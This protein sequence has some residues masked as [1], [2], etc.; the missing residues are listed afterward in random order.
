MKSLLLKYGKTILFWLLGLIAFFILNEVFTFGFVPLF[1]L[2]VL[3]MLYPILFPEYTD[4]ESLQMSVTRHIH[5]SVLI[6]IFGCLSLHA[7][8]KYINPDPGVF[9]NND[10]HALRI[11]GVAINDPDDF[12]L[13]GNSSKAFLD[14]DEFN[15]EL[16][17]RGFD[18]D[19]ESVRLELKGF[20]SPVYYA[21]S[22]KQN[23]VSDNMPCFSAGE[24]VT[25]VSSLKNSPSVT[26]T[27]EENHL[28]RWKNLFGN[29][30][31]HNRDTSVYTFSV[32]NGSEN[33]QSSRTVFIKNGISLADMSAGV[34]LDMPVEGINVVRNIIRTEIDNKEF[35]DF[36][37]TRKLRP[38]GYKEYYES[39]G[40]KYTFELTDQAQVEKIIVNGRE[41]RVGKDDSRKIDIKLNK[42]FF[43]GFADHKTA[44]M[45]F[46]LHE[47]KL[48]LEWQLPKY[49][50][51]SSIDGNKENTVMITT[52][53]FDAAAKIDGEYQLIPSFTENILLFNLFEKKDNVNHM[54]PCYLSF[55]S[56]ASNVP[57]TFTLHA[58]EGS[59]KGLQTIDRYFRQ[60]SL[61]YR[62]DKNNQ[63]KY[64]CYFR[65][66]KPIGKTAE[67]EWLVTVENFKETTPFDA[68]T[69]TWVLIITVLCCAV[70]M[71]CGSWRTYTSVEYIA[72]LMLIAFLTIRL[73]L[74]WRT[75]VFVP[76]TSI[77]AAEFNK[78]RDVDLLG[79]RGGIELMLTG[80]F[81]GIVL[82]KFLIVR[83]N[84]FFSIIH[85]LIRKIFAT[86]RRALAWILG[87]YAAAFLFAL[88]VPARIGNIIIPVFVAI[89]L[90]YLIA[91]RF[92]TS[93]MDDYDWSPYDD[94]IGARKDA[95]IM[96]LI[97]LCCV[98]VFTFVK[99]A[100]FGVMFIMFSVLYM[101]FRFMDLFL[102]TTS[103]KT[104]AMSF[105]SDLLYFCAILFV[106]FYKRLFIILFNNPVL[107]FI[108]LF[109][110]VLAV[111]FLMLTALNV[112]IDFRDRKFVI[113]TSAFVSCL[114]LCC[115]AGTFLVPKFIEG[116]HLEYRIRVHMDSSPDDVM[117]NHISTQQEQNKFLQ[118]SLND[119]ILDEYDYIGEEVK[120]F[121]DVNNRSGWDNGYFKMQP[122]S[123]V[124]ALW[125]AQTSDIV[126]SRYIIAEHSETL[127]VLFIIAYVIMMFI[128]IRF[129]AKRRWTKMLIVM[130]PMLLATQAMMIWLANTGRFI[131]F[132]QDFPLISIN[133]K[134]TTVYFV[135]LIFILISA[136]MSEK[137]YGAYDECDSDLYDHTDSI[138]KAQ[139]KLMLAAYGIVM[140]I[141]LVTRLKFILYGLLVFIAGML[142]RNFIKRP[143]DDDDEVMNDSRWPG[144]FKFVGSLSVVLILSFFVCKA[145]ENE[146]VERG[147]Y[148]LNE[149][150]NRANDDLERINGYFRDYQTRHKLE[151]SRDMSAMMPEF[152]DSLMLQGFFVE[153]SWHSHK[154]SVGTFA[155]KL[156][157]EYCEEGS[158]SNSINDI[159]YVRN[160]RSFSAS[161]KPHDVLEF[162]LK[163][164]YYTVQLPDRT[165][166]TWRGSIV[167]EADAIIS[168][169]EYGSSKKDGYEYV[170]LPNAITGVGDKVIFKAKPGMRIF[171]ST[172]VTDAKS[173]M[174][175]LC[176]NN[177]DKIFKGSRHLRLTSSEDEL[178]AMNVQ[179]NGQRTFIY[180]RGSELFWVRD[181]ASQVMN[182]KN[183]QK[184]SVKN[185]DDF[186]DDVH[187][188]INGDLTSQIYDV[189]RKKVDSG[190]DRSVVVA[191]GDGRIRAMVDYRKDPKYRLNPNDLQEIGNVLDEL[192]INGQ[193]QSSEEERYFSTFA[194]SPLRCGPGSSQKPIVWTAVT[195]QYHVDWWADL[196]LKAID[197]KRLSP[198]EHYHKYFDLPFYAG[199]SIEKSFKSIAGDEGFD[200]EKKGNRDVDITRDV[201][202]E[203]Y[204]E[205]SSNY[206]NAIMAYIGTFDAAQLDNMNASDYDS[207]DDNALFGKPESYSRRAYDKK[208]RDTSYLKRFPIMKIKESGKEFNFNTFLDNSRR[209]QEN[210]VL[211]QGLRENFSLHT[212]GGHNRELKDTISPTVSSLYPSLKKLAV[213]KHDDGHSTKELK[214][215]VRPSTSYFNISLRKD[216]KSEKQCNEYMVRSVAI[217]TNSAWNVSPVKM[218]EMYARAVTL[219]RSYELTLDPSVRPAGYTDFKLHGDWRN[220]S[221]YKED[222]NALITGMQKVFQN[223]GSAKGV[224]P[225]IDGYYVYGKT[226]TIDGL[227]GGVDK[228]DH[229]LAIMITDTE[230]TPKTDLKSIRFYVAY[231]VDYGKSGWTAINREIIEKI[232]SSDEFK[233][234]MNK[235]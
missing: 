94:P 153:T 183:S 56:S 109:F 216:R 143:S 92:S 6:V 223:N 80:L 230:I 91:V 9:S 184:S 40:S 21:D 171:G 5:T 202:L 135:M 191:D 102:T 2:L 86:K 167:G 117:L 116:S 162:A 190:D 201:T 27:I 87:L 156:L 217:G 82:F 48:T 89:V 30:D 222:R 154:D 207:K 63:K 177:G 26:F 141:F 15:G 98:S 155:V 25:V 115:V 67:T 224:L 104:R 168:K 85:G 70:L 43:I 24:K 11:D 205:K 152:M 81:V 38:S 122:Q 136:A 204:M 29:L 114:I 226:G 69:I 57:M 47:G 100:G 107:F 106:V 4:V 235:K 180:P 75:S 46:R 170:K 31:F 212:Y 19:A 127:A 73:F 160:D 187:I 158:K 195:S 206:Y 84:G 229:L 23:L 231:F 211:S 157:K 108:I 8:N 65:N 44:P 1:I 169:P 74:L 150:I 189:Y 103:G 221:E 140:I 101:V 176:L 232:I 233:S 194:I 126:L 52:S 131:F 12:F 113:R 68:K 59:S 111:A 14:N 188:T 18:E 97:N 144:V 179:V 105:A 225:S 41:H 96:T 128:S 165:K 79:M 120:W 147:Q 7:L 218:A 32:K 61:D 54:Q 76:V 45:V 119:W 227:Y 138:N 213:V 123:K 95:I 35:R 146:K 64:D 137:I 125:F 161:G 142:V 208:G 198:N 20:T 78:F 203:T 193:L 181:F 129:P 145:F 112:R 163:S 33:V 10:H 28:G 17:V 53:L 178:Y 209:M 71:L 199:H 172:N 151:Y 185:K 228:E 58:N 166:N 197:F 234:Y 90:E 13:A 51:L 93:Y 55:V 186:H 134:M 121:T 175:I 60:D 174:D 133:S 39:I 173:N 196:R 214:P 110:A 77:T 159:L 210:S 139:S 50:Y 118:A 148:T 164:D 34:V 36:S 200:S 99:D 215:I 124:G 66:V 192:E 37:D 83:L 132:G 22:K 88:I 149:V 49:Q 16:W 219:N 62:K 72:Y 3:F 42:P 130:I 182:A 220:I